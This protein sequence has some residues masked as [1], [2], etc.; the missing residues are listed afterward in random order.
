[1]RHMARKML[2]AGYYW[3]TMESD[4][5]K[6]VKK[7][8]KCQIY[9][10]KIHIPPTLLNVI[11]SPWPFSMWGI[12]MIGMI[13]PKASNGHRFILVAIDYF[14]KWV[15]AASYANVTRP[16]MNGAIEAD[17]KNIRKIIQ[18]MVVTYKDWHEMLPFALHG[19]RTSVCT[20]TGATPFSLVYGME[21]VL[22]VEVEIPSMRVLI[23]A[24]L[25]DVEWV[26]RRYDQLNLIEE[27]RLNSMC[28]GQ[29]YQQRMKKAFDKKVKPCVFRE[30]DLVLK[31]VL[32]FAPDSR[33]KWTPHYEGPYV[34][35]RAFSGG[36]LILTTMD[37]EDFTR[38][39][40]LDAV[41][42]Y[43]A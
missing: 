25:T 2:R 21:A 23:E 6:F 10:D 35:K 37:G 32:S 31:K 11:S 17:N 12:D 41:K 26:Q 34:V 29:L 15:E 27:K 36:A 14:T 8:H 40:N 24:K 3:L 22:P 33:G 16:K 7:C 19:Y 28:H 39:V 5:C 4:C 38:P 43:F 30:G 13:E 1:M 42:K 18:K 9:A 20:S